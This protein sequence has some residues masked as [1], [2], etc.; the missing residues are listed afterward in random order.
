MVWSSL[1]GSALRAIRRADQGASTGAVWVEAHGFANGLAQLV[2]RQ[3]V[4][5]AAIVTGDDI[6]IVKCHPVFGAVVA[7]QDH[8]ARRAPSGR[9]RWKSARPG[10]RASATVMSGDSL[11]SSGF[12]FTGRA[13][14]PR[15]TTGSAGLPLVHDEVIGDAGEHVVPVAEQVA[16]A[17]AVAVH[18]VVAVA[19]RDELGR[20]HGAGVGAERLVDLDVVVAREQEELRQLGP[21]EAAAGRVVEGQRG[22][23][24]QQAELAGALAEIGL[25]ADDAGEHLGRHAGLFRH[26]S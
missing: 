6:E 8:E 23:A 1:Q 4:H 12:W 9:G 20:A 15:V 25:H 14:V 7:V 2:H 18:R 13:S 16:P 22:E 19:A 11:L 17:V 5:H 21:E 10:G 24:V 26:A 3:R